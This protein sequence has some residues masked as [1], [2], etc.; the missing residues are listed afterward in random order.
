M[1][2]SQ[3]RNSFFSPGHKIFL[4]IFRFLP[5]SASIEAGYFDIMTYSEKNTEFLIHYLKEKPLAEPSTFQW[6]VV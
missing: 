6:T 2:D 3:K 1:G 5:V 4:E